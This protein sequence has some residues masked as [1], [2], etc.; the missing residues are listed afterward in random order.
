MEIKRRIRLLIVREKFA[1]QILLAIN[2][3][4][5]KRRIRLLIVRE[6][7]AE[8]ILLATNCEL[9]VRG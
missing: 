8:Q 4:E 2:R 3:M 1:E 7:F 9:E 6:K 5:I